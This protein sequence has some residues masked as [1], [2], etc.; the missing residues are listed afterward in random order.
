MMAMILLSLAAYLASGVLFAFPFVLTGVKR[1]DRHA[2][3]GSWGFRILIFPGTIFLWP[4]LAKRWLFGASE[5]PEE[6]NSH[7]NAAREAA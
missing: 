1:I 3:H 7:R 6:R 4:L 5:P 2:T